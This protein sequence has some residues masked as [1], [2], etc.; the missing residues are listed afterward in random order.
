MEYDAKYLK[1]EIDELFNHYGIVFFIL[2]AVFINLYFD[3]LKVIELKRYLIILFV[4]VLIYLF[5]RRK[6]KFKE[7]K[8]YVSDSVFRKELTN[9]ITKLHWVVTENNNNLFKA[10]YETGLFSNETLIIKIN[11][12]RIRYCFIND[13]KVRGAA[14]C[15]FSPMLE[16]RNVEK[17]MKS[18]L[19]LN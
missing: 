16:S 6:L 2:F 12:G 19:L 13:P 10:N 18:I 14:L 3:S 17:T 7:L 9:E 11:K 1:L 5:Q 4:G 8:L 15:T